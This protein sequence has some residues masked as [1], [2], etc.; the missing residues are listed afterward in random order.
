MAAGA[1]IPWAEFK[2]GSPCG[3]H[4]KSTGSGDVTVGMDTLCTQTLRVLMKSCGNTTSID[5]VEE[6]RETTE[7]RMRDE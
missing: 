1:T 6:E 4:T 7:R 3:Q 2:S 5:V